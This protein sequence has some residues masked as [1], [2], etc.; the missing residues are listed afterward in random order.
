M[1]AQVR[2]HASHATRADVCRVAGGT[3]G[4]IDSKNAVDYP[5]FSFSPR[6]AALCSVS[7]APRSHVPTRMRRSYIAS[8]PAEFVIAAS[9]L[10]FLNVD[11]VTPSCHV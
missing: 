6:H 1:C 2:W 11:R 8:T 5:A 4:V 10:R 7:E 3:S 9:D